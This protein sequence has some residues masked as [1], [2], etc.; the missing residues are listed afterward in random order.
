MTKKAYSGSSELQ[1]NQ[2]IKRPKPIFFNFLS[3]FLLGVIC[4]RNTIN[5]NSR[6]KIYLQLPPAKA[7]FADNLK[8]CFGGATWKNKDAKSPTELTVW[9]LTSKDDLR[10]LLKLAKRHRHKLPYIGELCD[11]LEHEL[12]GTSSRASFKTR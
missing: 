11:Y 5:Y 7:S 9:Q 8:Q 2:K 4:A 1:M 10:W 12:T 6:K 3:P